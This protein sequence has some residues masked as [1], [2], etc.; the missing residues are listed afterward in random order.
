VGLDLEPLAAAD[1]DTERCRSYCYGQHIV[2]ATRVSARDQLNL[3]L[4]RG[5]PRIARRFLLLNL[6]GGGGTLVAGE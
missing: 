3:P 2:L 4:V 5:T 1:N 6:I